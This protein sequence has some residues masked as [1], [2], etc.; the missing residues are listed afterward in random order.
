M[1][2]FAT[3]AQWQSIRFV[4]EGFR[5]QVPKVARKKGAE[6]QRPFLLPPQRGRELLYCNVAHAQDGI[7]KQRQ[8]L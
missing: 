5:V 8:Y 3:L 2:I 6:Y 7:G 1:N 4:S